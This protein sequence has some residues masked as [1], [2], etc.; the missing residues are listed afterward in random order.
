[1]E[2]PAYANGLDIRAIPGTTW[3]LGL[4][5]LFLFTTALLAIA[6]FTDMARERTATKQLAR[7]FS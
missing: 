2:L 6:L 7:R 4:V 5:T 1:M 3:E